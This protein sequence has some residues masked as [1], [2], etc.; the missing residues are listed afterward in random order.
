MC[1]LRNLNFRQL[2]MI[3]SRSLRKMALTAT[4][5]ETCSG[6]EFSGNFF[7]ATSVSKSRC[8]RK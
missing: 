1:I 8:D 6:K 7:S 5:T 2:N 4:L 3:E